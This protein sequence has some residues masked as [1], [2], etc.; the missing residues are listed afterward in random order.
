M[1]SSNTPLTRAVAPP[2]GAVAPIPAVLGGVEDRADALDLVPDGVLL[3]DG[4]GRVLWANAEAAS[5]LGEDRE[6]LP[7]SAVREVIGVGSVVPGVGPGR[8]PVD[9]MALRVRS[10]AGR[11]FDAE[12]SVR[13]YR[14]ARGEQRSVWVLH[15]VTR[16]SAVL[17]QLEA[18]A[19]ASL[20]DPLTGLHNRRGFA[21]AASAMLRLADRQSRPVLAVFVDLDGLKETNDR[22]GHR[23]GDRRLTAT[24]AAL[25]SV[26]R[27]SDIAARWG[28]DEFVVLAYDMDERDAEALVGRVVGCAP[29][30]DGPGP[31]SAGWA[32][33]APGSGELFDDLVHRA[34][35]DMYRRR[36]GRR[37]GR[38]D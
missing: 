26:W 18:D 1:E 9:R 29:D 5:L 15:D 35:L 21:A 23:A 38:S 11:G 6:D 25:A 8:P 17:H 34:D 32:A 28:G 2:D 37:P 30:A 19:E 33:Y 31:V 16:A 20:H 7:G 12:V 10:R 4:P 22:R 13:S 36:A 27:S 24:A 3:C 14:S